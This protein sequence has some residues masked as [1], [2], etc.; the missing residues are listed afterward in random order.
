MSEFPAR[1]RALPP[2]DGPF[3]ASRLQAEGCDVLFASYPA[4]T[5]IAPHTHESE[6]CG[7]V[8]KG[9]LIIADA[10][11][12]AFTELSRERILEGG[13]YWTMPLLA[14]GLIYCRNSEGDVV[15]RDHRV[16]GP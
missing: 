1:I 14:N 8:T 4:G 7:V 9:E 2:F 15:C 13:V 12:D 16:A 3:D 10:T 6:N 5:V 11:S